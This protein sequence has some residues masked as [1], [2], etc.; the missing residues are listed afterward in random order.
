M[1]YDSKR[2]VTVLFGGNWG[3][4]YQSD[5]WEYD[6]TSWKQRSTGG[7]PARQYPGMAFDENRGETVLLG[8]FGYPNKST[9]YGDTWI[10][11]GTTWKEH[12]G[13]KSP[14]VREFAA[15]T[16]DPIRKRALLWGGVKRTSPG[17]TYYDTWE[18]DG[19]KWTQLN[20]ILTP[21][22]SGLGRLEFVHGM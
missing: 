1:V 4:T 21:R 11:N 22:L 20:P 9:T 2:G 5:T 14:G 18:W 6:G 3:N 7:P 16:Y 12:F 13:I 19:A 8:G 10:W 17:K 15:M